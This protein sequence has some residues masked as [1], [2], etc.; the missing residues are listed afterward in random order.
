MNPPLLPDQPLVCDLTAI[1]APARDEHL[2]TATQIFQAAQSIQE[3]PNGYA[4]QL[5][6]AGEG[7]MA[8]ARFV[9][10]ERR[11]CPF[12][13]F[14]LEIEPNRGPLWLRLTGG[15]GV[16]ELLQSTLR[17]QVDG[18]TLRRLIQT[19][20]DA[21][22]NETVAQAVPPLARALKRATPG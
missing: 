9:E 4:L 20:D 11:C 12:F 6:N 18:A 3:L 13:R 19:G 5:P 16:K 2:Q 17:D 22:L 8:L 1:P 10:N 7:F 14:E 15:A 21:R